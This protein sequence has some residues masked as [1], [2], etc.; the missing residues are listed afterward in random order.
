MIY[1]KKKQH[2]ILTKVFK[3]FVSKGIG[4]MNSGITTLTHIPKKAKLQ[5]AEAVDDINQQLRHLEG[6]DW[7]DW[8][9]YFERFKA[10]QLHC[11]SRLRHTS[12]DLGE[13]RVL[14]AN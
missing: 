5:A 9:P 10:K 1:T 6:V 14:K 3:D 11:L 7:K 4:H 8:V 2:T 12:S 13:E